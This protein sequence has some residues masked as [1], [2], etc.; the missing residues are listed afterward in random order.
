MRP[1]PSSGSSRSSSDDE[2]GDFVSRTPGDKAVGHGLEQ[3]LDAV[4]ARSPS[5]QVSN[6]DG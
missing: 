2:V 6:S 5:R 1:P 4:D 3:D